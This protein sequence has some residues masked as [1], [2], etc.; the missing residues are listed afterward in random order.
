MFVQ[1]PIAIISDMDALEG[2]V[3]LYR[4]QASPLADKGPHLNQAQ[5]RDQKLDPKAKE[6]SAL[7]RFGRD[8][9]QLAKAGKLAPLVGPKPEMLRIAQ[10]LLQSRKNNVILVGEA[11]VGK[12]GIVEGLAQ[13]IAEGQV[14][15]ELQATHI[16]ELSMSLLVAGTKYRGEFEERLQAIIKEASADSNIVLYLDEIHM[17][18]GAGGRSRFDG[19]REYPKTCPRPW[20]NP[21]DRRDHDCRIPSSV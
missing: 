10:T 21:R 19:C 18:M 4:G 7:E 12:T 13:R 16:I 2:R 9:N 5:E 6:P 15:E 1:H 20:R 3:R 17:L 14:P 11:G 8:L